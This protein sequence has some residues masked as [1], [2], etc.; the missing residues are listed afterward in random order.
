[1]ALI[2]WKIFLSIAT[3]LFQFPCVGGET[4]DELPI[5]KF[6]QIVGEFKYFFSRSRPIYSNSPVLAAKQETI[7]MNDSDREEIFGNLAADN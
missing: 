4:G 2:S 6:H 5:N 3:N 7:V 1:M